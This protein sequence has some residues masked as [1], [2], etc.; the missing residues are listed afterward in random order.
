MTRLAVLADIH[1]NLPALEAVLAD[2]QP[3]NV[4]QVVVAGDNINMGPYSVEVM[5]R[6]MGYAV[7]RGNHEYYLLDHQTPRAPA[8]WHDYTQPPWLNATIPARW[9]SV[10]ATL[11]DALQLRFLMRRWCAWC[12]GRR[13]AIGSRFSPARPT[14]KYCRCCKPSKKTW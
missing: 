9:R 2:I 1:G 13:A 14:K 8:H 11:P 10:I 6:I 3:F 5:E 12:M 7:M 4:D